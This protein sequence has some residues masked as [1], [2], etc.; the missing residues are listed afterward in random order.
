M[1]APE[2]PKTTTSGRWVFPDNQDLGYVLAVIGVGLT[3][4][5]LGT[6][7]YPHIAIPTLFLVAGLIVA[8]RGVTLWIKGRRLA[9]MELDPGGLLPVGPWIPPQFQTGGASNPDVAR[10][11]EVVEATWA[12]ELVPEWDQ[13]ELKDDVLVTYAFRATKPGFFTDDGVKTRVVNK[14]TNA[15]E[16][17][18]GSW[19]PTFDAKIDLI[20]VSQKS[21]FKKIVTPPNWT[22]VGS[23]KEARDFYPKFEYAIGVDSNGEQIIFAPGNGFPHLGMYGTTG[24]GKSVATRAILE[25][26]RAAGFMLFAIDGKNTDYS[27]MMRQNGVV[28]VSTNL[29]EHVAVVHMVRNIMNDRRVKG[30]ARAKAGDST[31]RADLTPLV[32]VLDEFATVVNDMKTRFPKSYKSF[33]ADIA[34]ILKVGREFR[35]H[36]IL[37]TQDMKAETVPSDW[38]AMLA[39]NICMG[40]PDNMTLNKGF[41][42]AVRGEARLKGDTISKKTRGRGIVAVTTEGGAPT[43]E[44]FQSYFSYSPAED[45]NTV[46]GAVKESWLAFKAAVTD[47]IPRLYSRAWFKPEIPD[48]PTDGKDTFADARVKSEELGGLVDMEVFDIEDIHKMKMVAL[49]ESAPGVTSDEFKMYDPLETD[50]YIAREYIEGGGMVDLSM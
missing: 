31:W 4:Y 17:T 41:P 29:Q 32:L 14:L 45:I 16:A 34:A 22:V 18:Q 15:V 19:E 8:E 1:T 39:V 26:F 13:W 47:R 42:E 21:S 12:E 28:A 50:H 35:C 11:L 6:V 7:G 10:V 48:A 24:G 33:M 27:S 36:V 30:S 2:Q 44:L 20:K 43:V 40:K 46:P 37:A 9:E 3:L 25:Q 5:G 38:Q 23:E 49:K